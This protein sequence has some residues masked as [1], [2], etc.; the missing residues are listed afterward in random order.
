MSYN[1]DMSTRNTDSISLNN[2]LTVPIGLPRLQAGDRMNRIEFERRYRAMPEMTDAEL[3]EGVVYMPSPVSASQH[4]E[5][6][7]DLVT[8]LGVYRVHTPG[9]RCGDNSSLRLDTVNMPQPDSYLRIEDQC[10]GRSRLVEGMIEGPPELIVEIAASS[11]SYDLHDKFTAYQRNQVQEYLVWRVLDRTIDWFELIDG[12][13]QSLETGDGIY[14]SRVFPGLWL[15]LVAVTG[16]DP[17]AVLQT[18]QLG[19]E[20]NDHVAFVSRLAQ[21]KTSRQSQGDG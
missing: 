13:F 9:V 17:R 20:S 14:R 15:N 2:P 1:G 12:T 8:W 7:A 16:D 4:G 3:V 11:V 5:P 18:L 10:G 19:I 6:H 21:T